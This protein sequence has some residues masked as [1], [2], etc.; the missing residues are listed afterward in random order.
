MWPRTHPPLAQLQANSQKRACF[1]YR[2]KPCVGGSPTPG[3][4]R[5]TLLTPATG[6]A[7]RG[8]ETAGADRASRSPSSTMPSPM[9]ESALVDA[10]QVAH[11]D[12]EHLEHREDDHRGRGEPDGLRAQQHAD[13]QQ[14]HAEGEP[15]RR[16]GVLLGIGGGA[17]VEHLAVIE[18]AHFEREIDE[19]ERHRGH[20]RDRAVFLRAHAARHAARGSPSAPPAGRSRAESR[21][22][23]RPPTGSPV[24]NGF[25][26]MPSPSTMAA[27]RQR[28]DH[29]R[30]DIVDHAVRSAAA[31]ARARWSWRAR[32][33]PAARSRPG[34]RRR[35]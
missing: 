30:A 21:L 28:R 31:D 34:S 26:I 7:A 14:R 22:T 29:E 25:S 23:K 19:R 6:Q 2:S 18:R 12:Q 32:R 4:K 17:V 10:G 9:N 16:I 5:L 13:H 11:V 1:L 3:R 15:H 27:E 35:R 8:A 24:K 20:G 33:R